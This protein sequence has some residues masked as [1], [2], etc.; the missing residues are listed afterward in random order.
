LL[1]KDLCNI[2]RVNFIQVTEDFF[3]ELPRDISYMSS[4]LQFTVTCLALQNLMLGEVP[5]IG[6]L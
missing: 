5:K 4:S 2:H 6:E 3:G 1:A